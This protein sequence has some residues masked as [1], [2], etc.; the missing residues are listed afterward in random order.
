[1]RDDTAIFTAKISGM[2]KPLAA[3]LYALNFTLAAVIAIV[4]VGSQPALFGS[5]DAPARIT[6]RA[7]V[8]SGDTLDIGGR[9]IR[10]FGIEAPRS[11]QNCRDERGIGY[12]CGRQAA[13]A[14]QAKIGART[15]ACDPRGV[16]LPE[17][18]PAVCRLGSEELNAWMVRQ[19]WAIAAGGEGRDYL[20]AE[21][22]AK[23]ERLGLWA[24]E[25]TLP[26]DW[27]RAR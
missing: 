24:G 19:G 6:G 15:V 14:L 22:Q 25:F 13:G 9:R 5:S 26:A 11:A 2:R 23:S 16:D 10:L 8:M 17:S 7:A 12:A 27:R 20:R 4:A 21:A 18:I 3:T 1:M